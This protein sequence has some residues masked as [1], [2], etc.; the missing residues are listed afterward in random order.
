MYLLNINYL[1]LNKL[2]LMNYQ[3]KFNFYIIYF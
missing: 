2:I 3:L 1:N